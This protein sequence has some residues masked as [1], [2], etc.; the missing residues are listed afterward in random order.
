M[1][2]EVITVTPDTPVAEL[3]ALLWEK[4]ISGVPVVDQEGELVGVVTESDLIDQTKRVHIPT[5]IG[6]LDSFLFLESPQKVEKEIKKMAGITVDDICSKDPVTV[7]EDTSLEDIATILSERK[8]HTLP[9]VAG[10]R[11]VGVVGKS[12]IIKTLM[13]GA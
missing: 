8:V 7:S 6:I 2:Q 13:P 1:T 3:A 10:K 9:V 11:I 4:R 5:V 12:D